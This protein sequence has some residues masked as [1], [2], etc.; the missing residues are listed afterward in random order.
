MFLNNSHS[1]IFSATSG[2]VIG[3]LKFGRTF[4]YL[5]GTENGSYCEV[6]Q[7]SAVKYRRSSHGELRL[8]DKGLR[9]T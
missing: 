5:M 3:T 4:F 2:R 1:L 9:K 7:T 6:L 8:F